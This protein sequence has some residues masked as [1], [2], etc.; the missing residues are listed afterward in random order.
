MEEEK[1][2]W[3]CSV[4]RWLF[5]T[6]AVHHGSTYGDVAEM[7]FLRNLRLSYW[8][9]KYILRVNLRTLE[10]EYLQNGS[11]L[12]GMILPNPNS[13]M[14]WGS[15]EKLC[16][17]AL[18]LAVNANDKPK[19]FCMND[20]DV[21][22]LSPDEVASLYGIIDTDI[23]R[24]VPIKS[25]QEALVQM[26]QLRTAHWTR[27]IKIEWEQPFVAIYSVNEAQKLVRGEPT[28][29][30]SAM[31]RFP[32]HI[33]KTCRFNALFHILQYQLQMYMLDFA[34]LV[35]TDYSR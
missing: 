25:C 5:S 14:T 3:W 9:S 23:K 26:G 7:G 31:E 34:T 6:I 8:Q 19:V 27:T 35:I 12:T 2:P 18:K 30:M 28:Q 1:A 20:K 29:L 13:F 24:E 10:I 17:S 11:E 4:G 32:E 22:L 16:L 33:K 15:D 21:Y